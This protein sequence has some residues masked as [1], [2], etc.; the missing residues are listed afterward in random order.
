VSRALNAQLTDSSAARAKGLRVGD[1]VRFMVQAFVCLWLT[2][3]PSVALAAPTLIWSDEFDGT[4]LDTSKWAIVDAED[5]YDAWYAQHNVEVSNGTLKLH[6]QEEDYRGKSWTGAKLEGTFHPQYKYLEARVRHTVADAKIWSAWWTIGWDDNDNTWQWPPEFDIFEFGTHFSNNPLQVYHWDTGSGHQQDAN[7][8]GL[9]ETQWHTYGVYWT[10]NES[11]VFYVDGQV[12]Y[13]AN[14]PAAGAQTPAFMLL[15]SSPNRDD[16]YSGAPLGAMEV[17]YVRV[18]DSPP[19][20][21]EPE[22]HIALN[23][24]ASASSQQAGEF[25]PA[26]AFDGNASTRWASDWSD[27]QWLQVDLQDTYEVDSIRLYW[28]TALGR[29]YT[30]QV[31]DNPAGPWTTA[32]QVNDNG[33][34]GWVTHEFAAQAGRFVRL[35]GTQ[36]GTEW[37]YSLYEFEVYGDLPTQALT[38]DINGDGFVGIEDLN[39]VLGAWNDGTP[40]SGDANIPEP[41]TLALL[42]L[43]GVAV[44]RGRV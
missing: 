1:T 9:D 36:R 37:G 3:V 43:G 26:N 32:L 44:L 23:K 18:Y 30:I 24:P 34:A 42:G 27:P 15:S 28:E 38:G 40:P 29:D 12:S 8:T 2:G 33:I 22:V 39:I 19:A 20:Q 14:G 13:V 17:D 25:G 21:P 16:H 35:L 4:S 10:E 41:T 5:W 11:A 6:S 7:D 31:A